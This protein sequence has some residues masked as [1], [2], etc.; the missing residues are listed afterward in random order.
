MLQSRVLQ[1]VCYRLMLAA[2]QLGIAEMLKW[3]ASVAVFG[4]CSRIEPDSLAALCKAFWTSCHDVYCNTAEVHLPGTLSLPVRLL[5]DSLVL[6]C[7]SIGPHR[8]GFFPRGDSCDDG[9][10]RGPESGSVSL[11]GGRL[12]GRTVTGPARTLVVVSA[13]Q[14]L[15]TA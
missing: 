9:V 14:M 11:T 7:R 6:A 5:G 13:C 3:L 15:D 8:G 12:G 10:L 4:S 1:R 2:A